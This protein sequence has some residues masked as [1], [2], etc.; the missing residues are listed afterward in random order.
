MAGAH[1][2]DRWMEPVEGPTLKTGFLRPLAFGAG[3]G[4][5]VLFRQPVWRQ[6]VPGDYL[7][8]S[9]FVTLLFKKLY[10]WTRVKHCSGASSGHLS[11]PGLGGREPRKMACGYSGRF[12]SVAHPLGNGLAGGPCGLY[13]CLREF[14][15]LLGC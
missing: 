3:H 8:C 12:P 9:V 13:L 1:V 7:K 6:D 11:K 15:G 2:F 14:H 5:S 4:F 10:L